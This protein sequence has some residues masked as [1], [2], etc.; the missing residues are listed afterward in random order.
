MGD[1]YVECMVKRTT[2]MGAK[3]FK[4]VLWFLVIFLGVTLFMIMGPSVS[5]FGMMLAGVGVYF[6]SIFMDVEYEY[7]YCDKTITVDK[8]YSQQRRKRVA[9][10]ELDKIEI[11]APLNSHSLDDYKNRDVKETDYSSGVEQQPE[12]RYAFY[13]E[14]KQKIVFE[15]SEK[16]IKAMHDVAPR[17]VIQY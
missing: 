12:V 8:I 7:L 13:Y 6:Y 16:M 3:I 9:V 11:I 2:G 10:Y 15:P 14:G 4:Y 1:T 17:K 5:L